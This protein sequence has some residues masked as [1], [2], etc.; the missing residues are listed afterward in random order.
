MVKRVFKRSISLLLAVVMVISCMYLFPQEIFAA[1]LTTD[2]SGLT[3]DY[4]NGTWTASGTT[5]NGSATGTAQ[6][7]CSNATSETSTLT[8]K[9]SS[10]SIAQL[11]FDYAKPTIGSGGHVKIDGT[12]VTAASGIALCR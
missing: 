11:S 6:G 5:L 1:T 4:T 10:G 12:A 3:A 7:S 2:I 9:N 8:L